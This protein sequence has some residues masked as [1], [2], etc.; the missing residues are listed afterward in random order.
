MSGAVYL[1]GDD[2]VLRTIEED[3]LPFLRDAIN[4][5]DV[6]RYLP[7]RLPLNLDGE[8][9]F[10]EEVVVGDDE[11][12]NLLIWTDDG[13]GERRAGTIGVHGLGLVDGSCEIGLFL[14]PDA[15]GEGIGTEASRLVTEWAFD[16]RGR[17]R[18]TARVT[19]GNVGSQAI[20]EKL[21]FRHEATF[22]EAV[23]HEGEYVDQHLYAVLADEWRADGG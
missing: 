14:V 16:D 8:R 22:R 9:E 10:Y 18:V 19:E 7:S 12:L 3:D 13:D 6:R 2:V 4:D 5:P 21:G 15:W 20:W 1:E 17:H 23:F 11:S